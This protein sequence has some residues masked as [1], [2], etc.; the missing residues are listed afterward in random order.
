VDDL[1]T[2]TW[3]GKPVW[4]WLLFVAVVVGLM[5][6]DFTVLHRRPHAIGARES[7]VLSLFYVTIGLGWSVAIFWLY[8]RPDAPTP[9]DPQIALADPAVRGRR[10]VELYLTGY[11]LEYALSLDNIFVI[12]VILTYLSIPRAYHRRVLVWGILGMIV[13]RGIFIG[14]GTALVAQ[15]HWLLYLFGAFLIYTGLKLIAAARQDEEP[16]IEKNRIVTFVRKRFPV[17]TETHGSKLL[18]RLTD[19][20]TGTLRLFMTPIMLAI[21]TVELVDLV[22]AVDSIPAILAVTFEPYI[23]YTSNVFA[24]L[25]LQALYFALSAMIHRFEYL[26]YAIALVLV[27]IGIKIL[28]PFF[29][30]ALAQAGIAVELKIEP[31]A[32]LIVTVLLLLGGV[33]FSLLKTARE[34]RSAERDVE[35]R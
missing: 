27:F 22:F 29:S 9:I 6:F 1:I 35:R 32:S 3:L 31:I 26:K 11:L 2:G 18:V 13:L 34:P 20:K 15:L 30:W 16:D 19:P 17:T 33:I 23:V 21:V 10:A 7:A 25:G 4:L 14:A 28:L 12:S 5:V 8:S 24:V